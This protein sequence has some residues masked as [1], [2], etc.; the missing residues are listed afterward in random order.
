MLKLS[1][2]KIVNIDLEGELEFVESIFKNFQ[3]SDIII[4]VFCVKVQLT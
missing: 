1:V 2:A 4:F 3:I